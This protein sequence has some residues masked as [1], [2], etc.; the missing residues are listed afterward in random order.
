MSGFRGSLHLLCAEA[1]WTE[2]KKLVMSVAGTSAATPAEQETDLDE[3]YLSE[4]SPERL[5]D[6][7][8][9]QEGPHKW[10][11]LMIAC[12]RAPLD[13]IALLCHANPRACTIPDRSGSLPIHFCAYWRRGPF[14]EVLI[15][16]LCEASLLTMEV[17]NTWGHTPLHALLDAKQPAPIGCLR[18]MLDQGQYT[19]IA[20]NTRDNQDRLPLHVAAVKNLPAEYLQ[21]LV[22]SNREGACL[23]DK[24]GNLPCHLLHIHH[25]TS[26]ISQDSMEAL[27][28]PLALGTHRTPK[29]PA[30]SP[31]STWSQLLSM[32]KDAHRK[33]Q[34]HLRQM[35]QKGQFTDDPTPAQVACRRAGTAQLLPIHLAALF[36][37]KLEIMKGICRQFPE[38]AKRT[39]QI[40]DLPPVTATLLSGNLPKDNY[41]MQT[42]KPTTGA[43]QQTL[44][45]SPSR[46]NEDSAT[47]EPWE[48]ESLNTPVTDDDDDNGDLEQDGDKVEHASNSMN[49]RGS[50]LRLNGT[51]LG[52]D[53]ETELATGESSGLRLCA[54]E[55][56][57]N[58]RAF[59]ELTEL[60]SKGVLG[61][62]ET[63]LATAK[64]YFTQRA[65]LLLAYYPEAMDSRSGGDKQ[66][67]TDESRVER[68]V[69]LIMYEVMQNYKFPLSDTV[70]RVWTYMAGYNHPE[71]PRLFIKT[72][73]RIVSSLKPYALWRL[74][75]VQFEN[76]ERFVRIAATGRTVAEEA[77]LRSPSTRLT[78]LFREY[79]FQHTLNSWLTPLDALNYSAACRQ[80]RAV[81]V[82]LLPQVP[83]RVTE[84]SWDRG[85]GASSPRPW[86]RLDILVTPSCTHTVFV[87][88]YVESRNGE[89]SDRAG[90]GDGS[91]QL[92]HRACGGLLV[93]RD[94]NRRL[95]PNQTEPWGEAVVA[96]RRDA[97]V[98]GSLVC[99]SFHHVPGRTYGLWHYNTGGRSSTLTVSDV[100]VRQLVHSCDAQG[101]SPLHLLLS[102]LVDKKGQSP[103]LKMH[104]SMLLAAKFG[105]GDAVGD[106]PLHYAL[107]CGVSEDVLQAIISACPAALVE[108]DKEGR[109]PMHAALLLCKDEPPSLGVTRALLSPPGENAIKLKDSSGRLPLHIAAERGAGEGILRLLVDA[110]IDGCYRTNKDGDLPLQ[111]LVRSG[112]ATTESV[113]ILLR[114]IMQNQ[115]ICR[116]GGSHGP[117]LPLHI[118][119]EYQCSYKVL[120]KLLL[121]Y[122]EAATVPRLASVGD[123]DHSSAKPKVFALD[124]LEAGK[125][126]FL[127]GA[128]DDD[129]HDGSFPET[130]DHSGQIRPQVEVRQADFFVRSDLVFVYN[131]LLTSPVTGKSYRSDRE[132]IRRLENLIRRE[133]VQ[134]GEDRKINRRAKLTEMAKHAWIFLCTYHNPDL[135]SDNFAGTVRRILRGLSSNAV[136]VLAHVQNPKSLPVPNL[137]AKECATPVCQ[138]LIMSRLR[139]VGRYV[140]YDEVH[141]VHKSE[142][143]LVMR[144]KDHGIED[145]YQTIM[146]IYEA[147]DQE[148]EDDISDAGSEPQPQRNLPPNEVTVGM[149]I[150]FA[151]KLGVDAHSARKEV[152]RL[153]NLDNTRRGA[154]GSGRDGKRGPKPPDAKPNGNR[155]QNTIDGDDE[156]AIEVGKEAFL[157]FC[158]SHRLNDKGIRS[159][160]IKFMRSASQFRKEHEVRSA[161]DVSATSW[162]VVPI[163]DD[164]NVDRIE[165]SRRIDIDNFSHTDKMAEDAISGAPGNK[166]ELY[167]L[168]IQEKNTTVHNF[169]HYKYAVVMPAGDRDLGEISQHEELGILQIREYMLQ[170]GTAL[171]HLHGKGKVHSETHSSLSTHQQKN[172]IRRA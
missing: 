44:P 104:V 66:F 125:S 85:K 88:F 134:C 157:A 6:E 128:N 68:L 133:A 78:H 109:T 127:A 10:T 144:A 51:E 153:G 3:T 16:I 80:T 50:G 77:E 160:V 170:V 40:H 74:T 22:S 169:A 149:V 95:R 23:S 156:D 116:I 100:R 36:G 19:S 102:N 94:D 99:L 161:L 89:S 93:V 112:A 26:D 17:K 105:S 24:D 35:D 12:V 21:A 126:A 42:T 138:L 79:W 139:F 46:E 115:S 62:G 29:L 64:A 84:A 162:P 83:L 67:I 49:K 129:D 171:Q 32:T 106:V 58:G 28:V 130:S 76:R 117:N 97:P 20:L 118:A 146:G 142:S 145:E 81:G 63:S 111:L 96:F 155:G 52:G 98:S 33:D 164:Y 5:Q 72:V 167:A 151:A 123:N 152:F 45:T 101:H 147:K 90:D 92:D 143:C 148:V 71:H 57:E 154:P 150:K 54:L 70:V 34:N 137:T 1:E 69:Q 8:M 103:K 4:W 9:R 39:V 172:Q 132:R 60:E 59:E 53:I 41:A 110:Y 56:F 166:D 131:P 120:E 114:P 13:V 165:E 159:V 136:D 87:T 38:G 37:V 122:G 61:E 43:D 82:R 119:T 141:P 11:P 2:V 168:D 47:D 48:E 14:V 86:Q 163:L 31:P 7:L 25:P 18:V 75:V 55:V 27:L 73:G 107:K 158:R 140:L 113:E 135:P 121:T 108:T 65:D 91:S 15:K 124:I 30:V